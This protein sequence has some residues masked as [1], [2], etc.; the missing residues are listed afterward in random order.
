[1][2]NFPY[3]AAT[4]YGPQ[5]TRIVLPAF[6]GLSNTWLGVSRLLARY[7]ITNTVPFSFKRPIYHPS[8]E[9]VLAVSWAEAPYVY[10]YKLADIGDTLAFPV[11]DGERIG[12]TAYIEVWSIADEVATMVN[13]FTLES[14]QLVEPTCTNVT[15]TNSTTTIALEAA[16]FTEVPAN[17]ECN[18]FCSPLCT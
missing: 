17:Q 1:M 18:P 5:F 9:F 12:A 15:C 8:G 3:A 2:Q 13:D 7:P 14:S 4:E 6:S 10:R 11:Y 16:V